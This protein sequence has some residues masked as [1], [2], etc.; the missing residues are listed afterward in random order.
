MK[1]LYQVETLCIGVA[2]WV[3]LAM[4]LL[5]M[6]YCLE[7]PL[8]GYCCCI[9]CPI[10]YMIVCVYVCCVCVPCVCAMCVCRVCICVFRAI[11]EHSFMDYVKGGCEIS[12]LVAVDFT[13]S[14]C[15]LLYTACC[16]LYTACCLLYTA[17]CLLYTACCLHVAVADG[18]GRIF[19]DTC[20]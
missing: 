2:M 13:V 11:P 10:T 15:C 17:C 4:Q 7:P 20:N 18:Q 6:I 5:Y 14:A 19:M 3:G 12:L 1:T 8:N 9:M 16:L